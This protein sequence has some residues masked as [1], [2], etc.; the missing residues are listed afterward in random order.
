MTST[1]YSRGEEIAHVA[2]HGVGILLSIVAIA[3]LLVAAGANGAGAWRATGGMLAS[4]AS[5]CRW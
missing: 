5:V 2:T 3:A 4:S 1:E